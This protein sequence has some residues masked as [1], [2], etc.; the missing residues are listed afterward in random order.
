MTIA[1]VSCG[2]D[3]LETVYDQIDRGRKVDE[4][5]MY[6]T[7]MEFQAIY[8]TWE[9]LKLDLE[10]RGIACTVLKPET[11]FLWDMLHRP[12]KKRSGGKHY[13]YAWCGGKCRWGT[14][15]KNRA[16]DAYAESKNAIVLV[17]IAADEADRL[18]KN[19][20]SYKRHPLI[21]A[22]KTEADC[23]AGCY[24]RGYEWIEQ[25][26]NGPVRLY[27]ILDRVSCWCC[28]NKNLW[29]LRNIY[30]YLPEYWERLQELQSQIDRPFKGYK[31]DGTP[32]GIFELE[33]R[34]EAE[35]EAM[36]GIPPY[37]IGQQPVRE[38][39]Y[40]KRNKTARKG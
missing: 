11:D 22:G 18:D 3:S 10:P 4:V 17:G 15:A 33:R 8:S 38:G 13:G 14:T 31:K 16:L 30:W 29:E 19:I 32:V 21:E 35:T 6:D 39:R 9:R 23:L 25:T 28:A 24:A 1:S 2:K 26:N 37:V 40:K 5:V 36:G 20:K 12:V 7:G 27:D 34:Y